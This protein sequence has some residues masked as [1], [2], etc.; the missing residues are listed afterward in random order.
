MMNGKHHA[1]RGGAAVKRIWTL[2][3]LFALA[4]G[5]LSGCSLR[6]PEELY[7]LPRLPDEFS[8][9]QEKIN[10]V[11][12]VGGIYAGGAEL[13]SPVSGDNT[14]TVQLQDLDGDGVSEAIAF[15]RTSGEERP[16][17]IYIF[18]R[19][20]E[21]YDI[22]AVIEGDGNAIDSVDY[23]NINGSPAKEM[24]VSWQLSANVHNLAA[25]TTQGGSMVQIMESMGYSRYRL[26]DVD[27]DG[28][29]E[30]LVLQV[31]T[32]DG[33]NRVECWQSEGDTLRMASAAPMSLGVTGLVSTT[34]QQGYLRSDEMIPALFVTS[35]FGEG[36]VTDVFAWQDEA[37]V[38]VTMDSELQYSAVAVR[39]NVDMVPQDING[40]GFTE[41]PMPVAFSAAYG[42]SSGDIFCSWRQ[43]DAQG[44]PWSAF[45]T[46][47]N[48]RDI[49]LWYFILPDEWEGLIT[50]T[51]REQTVLGERQVIF[52]YQSDETDAMGLPVAAQPFLTIYKL[53]GANRQSRAKIGERFVLDMDDDTIYCAEF[54]E[55]DWDCGLDQETILDHFRLVTESFSDDG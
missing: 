17:K 53:T 49:D 22:G 28:L 44:E 40:D 38:N 51:T 25:Y 2:L 26:M 13:I 9:L 5:M 11:T 35:Y 24:L 33:T 52:S 10:E 23:E 41:V 21:G 47:H 50:V 7:A 36:G 54:A 31:N 15:F 43:F 42:S 8:D 12:A 45:T 1:S 34:P 55:I 16:L 48:E 37:L 46:Y 14:Q 29:R 19:G 18:R 4:A 32:V 6:S 30:L 39:Q 27:R 3:L 20:E